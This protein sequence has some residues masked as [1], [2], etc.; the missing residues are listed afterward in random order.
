MKLVTEK[1]AYWP[2]DIPRLQR[3]EC[4]DETEPGPMAQAVI[5]RAFGAGNRKAS[6]V[7]GSKLD[8]G[9]LLTMV[10]GWLVN[11]LEI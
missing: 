5:F 7:D 8:A 4:F 3:S 10:S 9:Q 6:S 1:K 11:L 2:T